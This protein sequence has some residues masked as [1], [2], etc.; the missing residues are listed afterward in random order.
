MFPRN[1]GKEYLKYINKNIDC[2][3]VGDDIKKKT[4]KELQK[5][6][7]I[8]Q[9]NLSPQ[10]LFNGGEKLEKE[11]KKIINKFSAKPFIFNLA[12]GILPKTPIKNVK[13]LINLLRN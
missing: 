12:H 2:I 7:I 11:I 9:G 13:K 10:I 5:K 4:I 3:S 8:I 6:E 1:V